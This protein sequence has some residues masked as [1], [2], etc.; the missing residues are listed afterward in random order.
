[1]VRRHLIINVAALVAAQLVKIVVEIQTLLAVVV[2]R[3]Q[4]LQVLREGVVV[5][6][7]ALL[8]GLRLRFVNF[9]FIL[10]Q[11]ARGTPL[12]RKIGN[13]NVEHILDLHVL[14]PV[15]PI[16]E[17]ARLADTQLARELV[18]AGADFV[19]VVGHCWK[20]PEIF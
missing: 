15:R 20:L 6:A 4:L 7:R 17:L 3:L 14:Q 8:A 16:D 12:L 19:D 1:M 10:H 5:L 2:L 13:I 18:D 9:L 11:R